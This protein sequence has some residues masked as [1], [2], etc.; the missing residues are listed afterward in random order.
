MELTHD[1]EEQLKPEDAPVDVKCI[2]GQNLVV[3]MATRY[4]VMCGC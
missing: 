3:T 1:E 2:G 4:K